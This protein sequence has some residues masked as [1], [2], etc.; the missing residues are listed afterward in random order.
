MNLDVKVCGD[1]TAGERDEKNHYLALRAHEYCLGHASTC[2]DSWPR[3]KY[4]SYS[5]SLRPIKSSELDAFQ[6]ELDLLSLSLPRVSDVMLS[7][8]ETRMAVHLCLPL[9]A[10]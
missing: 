5:R 9:N 2:V 1:P 4:W 6:A 7:L 10:R 8:H 3:S